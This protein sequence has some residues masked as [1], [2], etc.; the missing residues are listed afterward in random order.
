MLYTAHP[1][2]AVFLLLAEPEAKLDF[3]TQQ[4]KLTKD[5]KQQ[6]GVFHVI[7]LG[8]DADRNPAPVKVTAPL[9]SGLKAGSAVTLVDLTAREWEQGGRK[10]VSHS[11]ASVKAAA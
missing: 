6:L 1:S 8:S 7:G 5:G 9:V 4:P 2:Y 11:A 10:G 3:E